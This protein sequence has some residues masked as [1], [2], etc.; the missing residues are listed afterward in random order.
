MH[1][2]CQNCILR[3]KWFLS[4]LIRWDRVTLSGISNPT[5]AQ[6][7]LTMLLSPNSFCLPHNRPINLEKSCWDKGLNNFI[8]KASRLRRWQTNVLENHLTPV[9]IQA[10]FIL[11]RGEAWLVVAD[12]LVQESFVLAAVHVGQVTMFLQ[13]S[14]R[15]NVILCSATFSL[16]MNG[17]LKVRALRIGC[18]VYFRL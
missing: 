12:F 1:F 3:P 6:L 4:F 7:L 10:S 16:C 9:R 11:K 8:Q 2:K 15:T 17:L 14:N 5:Y 18:P 13:T